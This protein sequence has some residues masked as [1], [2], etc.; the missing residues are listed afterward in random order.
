M[1]CLGSLQFFFI[2]STKESK[3]FIKIHSMLTSTH[4]I[5]FSVPFPS[6]YLYIVYSV[7]TTGDQRIDR[8]QLVIITSPAKYF[9]FLIRDDRIRK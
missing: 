4:L 5:H 2:L 1:E 6:I 3:T 8:L 9:K 7:W